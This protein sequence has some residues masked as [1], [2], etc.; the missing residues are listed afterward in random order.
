[1]TN[2]LYGENIYT[3]GSFTEPPLILLL[4]LIIWLLQ[5][6]HI[7]IIIH[8]WK[9]ECFSKEVLNPLHLCSRN[10][11]RKEGSWQLSFF[12][13]NC[14]VNIVTHCWQPIFEIE[15]VRHLR[16][17]H[18]SLVLPKYAHNGLKPFLLMDIALSWQ[19]LELKCHLVVEFGNKVPPGS[20][21]WN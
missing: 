14:L 15:F 2:L 1:M 10:E 13:G 18:S 20:N 6:K 8:I 5:N 4:S 19:N 16:L 9:K 12:D 17:L 21:F 3:S 11:K 7:H